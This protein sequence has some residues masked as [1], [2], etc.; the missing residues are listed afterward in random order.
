MNKFPTDAPL[1][2][3][4]KT[5]EMLDFNI[6]REKEHIAMLRENADGTKTL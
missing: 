4:I 5:F 2:S 1:R 6:I 3:V